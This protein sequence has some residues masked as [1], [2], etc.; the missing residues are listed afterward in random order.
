MSVLGST[1]RPTTFNKLTVIALQH[2]T[3]PS[4][5]TL[6]MFDLVVPY[7]FAV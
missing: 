3:T 2:I 1:I 7:L 4:F 6:D 5:V